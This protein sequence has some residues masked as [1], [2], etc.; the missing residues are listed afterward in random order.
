VNGGNLDLW[1]K[2]ANTLKLRLLIH[3]SQMSGFNPSAEIAKITANGGVLHAGENID[4]NPGY[5]NDN[6]KQSPFYANYGNTPTGSDASPSVRANDYFVNLVGAYNDARIE[7]FYSPVGNAFI[8][9]VYG[10]VEGNPAGAGSS[11]IGPGLAG[12]A[13]QD[14]WIF[15]AFESMF[16][17][18]EAIARGWMPG[19]AQTA[20][21]AAITENFVWLGV[22]DAANAASDY[23]STSDIATW[24]NAGTAVTDQAK[25]I[26]FQKYIALCGVDPVEAW[27]D[28]RRLNMLPA[29]YIS[30]NPSRISNTLPVRL[31]YPQSEYT[32]NGSNVRA[33]GTINQFTSKIFWQ[34]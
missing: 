3:Q 33:E 21:E 22:D 12:S 1:K 11:R 31:L 8:G 19:N 29:G 25:F 2:F 10:E 14:A 15:P 27:V 5:T 18:A 20:F 28:Q 6:N 9:D 13:K 7:R 24:S 30:K 4:V 16:L 23:I 34:Q 26:A 17:E 32:A